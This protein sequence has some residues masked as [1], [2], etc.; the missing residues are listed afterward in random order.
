MVLSQQSNR[1]DN[2][3]E[4]TEANTVIKTHRQNSMVV[5]TEGTLEEMHHHRDNKKLILLPAQQI[6]YLVVANFPF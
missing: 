4:N 6:H 2:L 3:M 5:D 1:S